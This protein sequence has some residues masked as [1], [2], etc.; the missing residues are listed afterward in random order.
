MTECKH[1]AAR[2]EGHGYFCVECGERVYEGPEPMEVVMGRAREATDMM[3][4]LPP[5]K[6]H[7]DDE[8]AEAVAA[9]WHAGASRREIMAR[10]NLDAHALRDVAK[11]LER[12]GTPLPPRRRGRK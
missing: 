2:D 4:L 11:R 6:D 3:A 9:L 10:M 8:R 12:K 7:W 1:R 5:R